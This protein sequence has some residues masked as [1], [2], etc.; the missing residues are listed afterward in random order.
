MVFVF[1]LAILEGEENQNSFGG[2][3][4]WQFTK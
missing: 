3:I 1:Q 2:Q 4:W